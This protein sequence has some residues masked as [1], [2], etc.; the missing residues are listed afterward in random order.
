[1][2]KHGRI[3]AVFAGFPTSMRRHR[4][5]LFAAITKGF[6]RYVDNGCQTVKELAANDSEE[7]HRLMQLI[8][9][10]REKGLGLYSTIDELLSTEKRTIF[11]RLGGGL[12]QEERS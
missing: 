8:A 10:R 11:L 1:M 12:H 7:Y 4:R 3:I 6:S 9:A 5:G 2:D